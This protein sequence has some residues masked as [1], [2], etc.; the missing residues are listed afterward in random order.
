MFICDSAWLMFFSFQCS[1]RS[2]NDNGTFNAEQLPHWQAFRN[3]PRFQDSADFQT[4]IIVKVRGV[5][6]VDNKPQVCSAPHG[7]PPVNSPASFMRV[8]K[9]QLLLPRAGW[10]FAR[11]FREKI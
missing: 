1:S 4:K 7:W 3:C 8:H 2:L 9:Q 6:F 5:V 11:S 10:D